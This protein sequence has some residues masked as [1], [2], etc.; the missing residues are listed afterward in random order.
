MSAG[1]DTGNLYLQS[2]LEKDTILKV[3]IINNKNS[4]F[5]Y[6]NNGK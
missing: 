4:E 3:Q 5:R 1:L 6:K 2:Q